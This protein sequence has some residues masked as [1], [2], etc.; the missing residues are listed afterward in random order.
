MGITLILA[1]NRATDQERTAATIASAEY[2]LQLIANLVLLHNYPARRPFVPCRQG[3][4][5]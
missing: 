3:V 1:G 2:C 4:N 5:V